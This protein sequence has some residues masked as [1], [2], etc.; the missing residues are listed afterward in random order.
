MG[1]IR[2]EGVKTLVPIQG[3][4]NSQKYIQVFENNLWHF[5]VGHD[6]IFQE[7]NAPVHTSKETTQ[8]K[9]TNNHELALDMNIIENVLRTLK[10][11]LQKSV[12]DI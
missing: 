2:Y 8:L 3:N 4:I 11:K 10:L 5:I 1:C 7:D 12:T 6:Y 9:T